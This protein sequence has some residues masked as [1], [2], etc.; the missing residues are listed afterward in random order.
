MAAPR[1]NRWPR[2]TTSLYAGSMTRYMAPRAMAGD[3]HLNR[4]SRRVCPAGDQLRCE[5][6]LAAGCTAVSTDL[7]TTLAARSVQPV[8]HA[9][10]LGDSRYYSAAP[11]TGSPQQVHVTSVVADPKCHTRL[12]MR[13]LRGGETLADIQT[14][15][16]RRRTSQNRMEMQCSLTA[17]ALQLSS[18]RA[19]ARSPL[20]VWPARRR[21]SRRHPEAPRCHRLP[22][23]PRRVRRSRSVS[24]RPR[25]SRGRS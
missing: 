3:V 10:T 25:S 23:T 14:R 13:V 15:L 6:R 9:A 20:S 18:S 24:A 1:C 16:P 12:R 5:E 17:Q 21:R 4:S 22:R 7:P 8:R 2:R 11:A 19:S